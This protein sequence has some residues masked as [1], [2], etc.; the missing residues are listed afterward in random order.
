MHISTCLSLFIISYTLYVHFLLVFIPYAHIVYPRW[1][2][3][4]FSDATKFM[5]NPYCLDGERTVFIY[6]QVA[7]F[8]LVYWQ[9]HLPL[10]TVPSHHNDLK[11]QQLPRQ[12]P[13]RRVSS[14]SGNIKKVVPAPKKRYLNPA[15]ENQAPISSLARLSLFSTPFRCLIFYFSALWT[16]RV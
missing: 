3:C 13:G 6:L 9:C 7:V 12:S 14:V 15:Q 5:C 8:F 2:I 16:W 4:L 10:H 11:C 1:C